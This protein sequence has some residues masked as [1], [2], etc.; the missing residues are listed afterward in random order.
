MVR[1]FV[2]LVLLVLVPIGAAAQTYS[3]RLAPREGVDSQA[4]GYGTLQFDEG[5]GELSYAITIE[6]LSSPEQAA[7]IHA[8]DGSILHP[9]PTGP[10]KVGVWTGMGTIESF[11]LQNELL[12]VLVHTDAVPAG[13][14]RGDIVLGALPVEEEGVSALK[15]R[16]R[17]ESR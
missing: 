4:S 3:V 13:E 6:G 9:L 14:I 7:H 10:E 2:V 1:P 12:Y 15:E 16:Y 5:R 17:E 11:Q 8:P